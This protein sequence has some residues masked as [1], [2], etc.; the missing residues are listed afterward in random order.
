MADVRETLRAKVRG[1]HKGALIQHRAQ[2]LA[3][4]KGEGA[5]AMEVRLWKGKLRTSSSSL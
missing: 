5:I 4:D 3:G 2:M 1:C